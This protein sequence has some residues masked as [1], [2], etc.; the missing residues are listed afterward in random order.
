MSGR[1]LGDV[2]EVAFDRRGRPCGRGRCAELTSHDACVLRLGPLESPCAPGQ[3]PRARREAAD[4]E[5]AAELAALHETP[6]I[7][8]TALVYLISIEPVRLDLYCQPP[9]SQR[10]GSYLR[11]NTLKSAAESTLR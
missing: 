4:A 11:T 10:K 9:A 2:A 1:S 7:E 3:T 5:E 6:F 8:V